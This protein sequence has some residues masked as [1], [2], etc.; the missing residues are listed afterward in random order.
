MPKTPATLA[1][2]KIRG[3]FGQGGAE[4]HDLHTGAKAHRSHLDRRS[5]DNRAVRVRAISAT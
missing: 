1:D 4:M 5:L 3:V 2:A